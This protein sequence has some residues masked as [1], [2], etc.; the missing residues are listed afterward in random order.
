LLT[1]HNTPSLT[2]QVQLKTGD[3]HAVSAMK[4]QALKHFIELGWAVML[5]DVD[6]AVLQVGWEGGGEENCTCSGGWGLQ[7]PAHSTQ[8]WQPQ[9]ST[10]RIRYGRRRW[11]QPSLPNFD[12]AA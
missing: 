12:A 10:R 3:N 8:L 1:R 11:L 9:C 6:I 7:L 2:P 4:Y 5:S